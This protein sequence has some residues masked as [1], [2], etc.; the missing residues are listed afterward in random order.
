MK[1]FGPIFARDSKG[2]IREVTYEVEENRYRSIHGA[3]GDKFVTDEW[4]IA[5]GKNVGRSNETTGEEQALLE[6]KAK[7]EKKLKSGGYWENIKDIDKVKFIEPMLAW[8]MIDTKRDRTDTIQYPCMVDRKYNGGRVIISK[9]GAFT[10]KGEKYAVIPHILESVAPLF[11]KYPDLVLDGEGY[12]HLFR[13]KLNAIM[14]ILR[15]TVNISDDLLK[16]SKDLVRLYVYDGYGFKSIS[17]N[18]PCFER[19]LTLKTLIKDT[20]NLVWVPFKQAN[21]LEEIYSIYNEYVEEGYEGAIIRAWNAA[22]QHKRT[23]DLLKV[24]PEND[25]EAIILKINEGTKGNSRGL[26]ATATIRMADGREFDATFKGPEEERMA[27]LKDQKSWIGKEVTF[28]YNDVTG[29]NTPNFAR[30]DVFNCFKK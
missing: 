4:T 25:D 14:S 10:R 16:R 11:E 20:P 18:T 17:E 12:N 21:T 2:K 5:E 1:K 27:I 7:W 23:N 15:T 29:K 9:D 6:A 28:T 3:Q 22:Y 26:A 30:I 13:Y 19:R 8:P 24:K